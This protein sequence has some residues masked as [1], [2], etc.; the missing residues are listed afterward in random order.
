MAFEDLL[1]THP[2]RIV[3]VALLSAATHTLAR[4]EAAA[5][6]HG[7]GTSSLPQTR[8]DSKGHS[9][10]KSASKSKASGSS[11]DDWA[12]LHSVKVPSH[13]KRNSLSSNKK[14]RSH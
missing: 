5:A 10:E 12:S 9:R 3:K 7:N 8:V 14:G 4:V 6:V 13:S 2:R 11:A 1:N